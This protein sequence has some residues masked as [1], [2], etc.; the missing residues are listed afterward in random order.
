MLEQSQSYGAVEPG[1]AGSFDQALFEGIEL[2]QSAVG[3]LANE[4]LSDGKAG[5]EADAEDE[6]VNAPRALNPF[7]LLV[8][9]QAPFGAAKHLE[10]L[11]LERHG[12]S[13]DRKS[14]K[15]VD[16]ELARFDAAIEREENGS[17]NVYTGTLMFWRP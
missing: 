16:P 9:P 1:A 4:A 3:E 10:S 14:G 2:P 13:A 11:G 5:V 12:N 6:E 15:T 17:P 8:D 7:A